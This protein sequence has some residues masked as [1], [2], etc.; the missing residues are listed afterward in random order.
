M[1]TLV[2]LGPNWILNLGFSLPT[3]SI[4]EMDVIPASAPNEAQLPYPMQL[5]SGTYD[6]TPGVTFSEQRENWSWG[7]QLLATFRS[8]T[9]DRDYTL[10]NR[11]QAT[12]WYAR[13]FATTW[14]WSVRLKYDDWDNIDGTD[15]ALNPM[16]VPTAEPDDG[17]YG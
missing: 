14:S 10:G 13:P 1:S 5:G 11:I 16:M 7:G 17:S 4:D 2:G 9:N 3:G 12:A 6:F 15:T 8:G